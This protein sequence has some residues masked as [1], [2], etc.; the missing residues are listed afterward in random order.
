MFKFFSLIIAVCLVLQGVSALKG[1]IEPQEGKQLQTNCG[2]SCTEPGIPSETGQDQRTKRVIEAR[3]V[4]KPVGKARNL[5]VERDP[6]S[7]GKKSL[8]SK[9][10]LQTEVFEGQP[11]EVQGAEM[12]P[13]G[14]HQMAANPVLTDVPLG[15]REGWV[16]LEEAKSNLDDLGSLITH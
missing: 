15:Q 7:Y 10:T 8:P 9:E 14:A 2:D 16:L 12:L 6:G 3:E 5:T 4:K 13:N 11:P 1:N